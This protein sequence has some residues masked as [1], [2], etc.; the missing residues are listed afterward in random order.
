MRL[1]ALPPSS[2]GTVK[3]ALQIEPKPGW[4]TYWREPGD[5]GIPPQL[6]VDDE[7]G[8]ALT[9]F[10]YPIPKR[11]DNGELKDI[12]YDHPVTFPFELSA[13]DLA[14]S[15]EIGISAFVG[16]CQ[17]ICIPFQ[18]EFSLELDKGNGISTEEAMALAR[19]ET[20]LPEQPSEEFA[21]THYA[22]VGNNLLR[23]TLR[24]PDMSE[25]EPQVIVTGP[26][27]H[28]FLD[29]RNG[30]HDDNRYSLEI[31]IEKLPKD[32]EISGKRWGILVLADD[33]AMETSLAFD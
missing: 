10:A 29:S 27:G 7:K 16:L 32:Y 15:A 25:S 18:A 22:L 6:T 26:E 28:V 11:I 14:A 19:A 23:L 8:I 4:M 21:V 24:L 9:R 33:R 1:I 2:D 20:K 13:A 31:P 5:A 30:R 12:G 3:G 17:N